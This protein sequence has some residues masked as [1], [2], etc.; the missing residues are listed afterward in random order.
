[1]IDVGHR[2]DPRGMLEVVVVGDRAIEIGLYNL[3]FMMWY[4]EIIGKEL[5]CNGLS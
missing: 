2:Q 5:M 4:Q 3:E 1:M